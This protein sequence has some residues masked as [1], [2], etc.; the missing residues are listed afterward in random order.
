MRTVQIIDYREGLKQLFIP[1]A[2]LLFAAALAAGCVPI[3]LIF[4]AHLLV[5]TAGLSEA[6]AFP[7]ATPTGVIL[8]A[9]MGVG[10]WVD[11]AGQSVFSCD[12]AK[13]WL[14]TSRGS[15]AL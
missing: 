4:L 12:H 2:L 5:Q 15:S 9:A 3:G 11:L 10:G 6:V 7:I 13:N 1:C 14:V 8:A